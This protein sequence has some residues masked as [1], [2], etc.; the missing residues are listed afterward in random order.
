[1]DSGVGGVG[2]F[3]GG[4]I[5]RGGAIAVVPSPTVPPSGGRLGLV[6]AMEL[7]FCGAGFAVGSLTAAVGAVAL[8]V[9]DG[10]VE[11]DAELAKSV[12]GVEGRDADGLRVAVVTGSAKS[13]ETK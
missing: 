2:A 12:F 4:E 1:M 3:G 9:E 7:L 13:V 8:A 11:E 6:L 10:A 5:G